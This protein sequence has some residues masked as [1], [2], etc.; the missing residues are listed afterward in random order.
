MTTVNQLLVDLRDFA[1]IVRERAPEVHSEMETRASLINPF[2]ETIGW[3]IRNPKV[4]RQEYRVDLSGG[5]RTVDYALF[6]SNGTLVIIIEAKQRSTSSI[7]DERFFSQLNGYVAH[8][9]AQIGVITNGVSFRW[10]LKDQ[11]TNQLVSKPCLDFDARNPSTEDAE[12]LHAFLGSTF[13]LDDAKKKVEQVQLKEAIKSWFSTLPTNPSPQFTR[14]LLGQLRQADPM[15]TI[16]QSLSAKNLPEFQ[17]VLK[18]AFK[19]Y[20]SDSFMKFANREPDETPAAASFEA[21]STRNNQE[22]NSESRSSQTSI[23]SHT[24]ATQDAPPSSGHDNATSHEQLI[25]DDGTV[26][27]AKELPRAYR[28]GSDTWIVQRYASRVMI[29]LITCFARHHEAGTEKYMELLEDSCK[30]FICR[31][32]DPRPQRNRSSWTKGKCADLEVYYRGINNREKIIFL[33]IASRLVNPPLTKEKD[34]DYWLPT[35]KLNPRK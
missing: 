23:Q 12:V 34:F 6:D 19:E 24:G 26:L 32:E 21:D 31:P 8:S 25:L 16:P 2:L 30:K 5:N 29:E 22:T 4:C 27:S 7:T 15:L 1:E 11:R 14:H 33:D 9:S 17:D 10:Y 28:F 3:D 20:Q 35:G 18:R 13:S